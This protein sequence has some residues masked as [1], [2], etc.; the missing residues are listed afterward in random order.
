MCNTCSNPIILGN[1]I[2]K[3]LIRSS[4]SVAA[5]YRASCLTKTKK[6]S[7]SKISIVIE[8]VDKSYF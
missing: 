5:N 6:S 8:E 7:I 2:K 1:H 3:Q 4:S